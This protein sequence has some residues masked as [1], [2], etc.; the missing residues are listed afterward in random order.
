MGLPGI[1]N[2]I[3]R[4]AMGDSPLQPPNRMSRQPRFSPLSTS[5][6]IGPLG[7][8]LGAALVATSTAHAQ[9]V[10]VSIDWHGPSISLPDAG[11]GVPIT[12]GDLLMPSN[13]TGTPVLG[14]P[15]PMTIATPHG[16]GGLGLMAGCIGHLPGTLCPVEVD[17]LSYGKD[18]LYLPTG[19]GP[20]DVWFSTDSFAAGGIVGPSPPHMGTEFPVGDTPADLWSNLIGMPPAPLPPFAA[21]PNHVGMVDGDGMPSGSGFAYP[22]LGLVEPNPPV[23]GMIHPGDTVDAACVQPGI[24]VPTVGAFFSLD[25]FWPDPLTGLPNAG[26]A[27]AHG[28]SSS[29]VLVS[30]GGAPAVFAPAF[31]LGLDIAAALP[32]DLDALI[33]RENGTGVF[34]PSMV[35][36]DWAGG[37]TDMLLFSVRRGSPVIGMPDSALGM[38]IE[39]G[40]ILTTPIPTFLGGV[41]PFPAIFIAAENLGLG[42]AR[43][44]TSLVLPFGEDLNA[45]SA[46]MTPL[47]DCN[48]N[49]IEDAIDIAMGIVPDVNM[50]GIPDPCEIGPFPDCNMNGID[51]AIDI[52]SGTS[53]DVN[54]N[55]IPDECEAVLFDCNMNGIEDATDISS[56]TSMDVNLNGIPDEC[57]AVLFDCNM[58]GIED[59]TDISSGTSMDINMNGIPDECEGILFDCNMNGIEDAIDIASGTS[60]D[61]NLNGIPDECEGPLLIT[62]SGCFCA[63]GAPCGNIDP[64][65]GCANSSGTG[66]LCT[67]SGSSSWALDDLV[68]TTTNVDPVNF[69]LYFMGDLTIPPVLLADGQRCL[70]GSLFRFAVQTS[71]AAGTAVMGPGIIAWTIA[72]LPPA[73]HI[74]IGSSWSFQYWYRDPGGPCGSTA[75]LSNSVTVTFTP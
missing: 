49:G 67:A 28:F 57:E 6:L 75:N 7:A 36:Y 40:D 2:V 27:M 16:F 66:A 26:S 11:G 45:L 18:K 1:T 54:M 41:S 20:G 51:D 55:G 34:E 30:T 65:A 73:G 5:R 53:A 60:L 29:D 31:L 72:N 42:T 37:A 61:L 33:L 47:F 22:G 9:D 32:D 35:P 15:F 25:A 10:I 39:E 69:G 62:S 44:G 23:L 68:L 43:S 63:T 52:S 3:S 64:L 56:G 46:P 50:N 17:A 38:P 13:A 70:S 71:D 48:V 58:N 74:A 8:T 21:P 12:E 4:D 14:A 59:A 19:F 24:V